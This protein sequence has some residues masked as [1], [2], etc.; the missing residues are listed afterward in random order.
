MLEYKSQLPNKVMFVAP[1][2]SHDDVTS[3]RFT[4]R[5]AKH[6]ASEIGAVIYINV[7]TTFNIKDFFIQI[8]RIRMCA[9]SNKVKLIVVHWGGYAGLVGLLGSLGYKRIITYHGPDLNWDL[10]RSIISNCAVIALSKLQSLFYT[11]TISVSPKLKSKQYNNLS[12]VAPMPVDFDHFKPDARLLQS[13][14]ASS[15]NVYFICGNDPV[16]KGLSLALRLKSVADAEKL[17]KFSI[18]DQ[19]IPYESL[20]TLL[21][22][23]DCLVF[24]SFKEGSPNIVR[25][26]LACNVPVVSVDVGDVRS[27]LHGMPNCYIVDRDPYL[28]HMSILKSING[29]SANLRDRAAQINNDHSSSIV[30]IYRKI[31]VN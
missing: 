18:F 10:S 2:K 27:V 31:M 19:L 14:Q 30:A 8:W 21:S 5:L 17:Y 9:K 12:Y 25:E 4:H 11:A 28:I 15:K 24:L 16:G 7:L 22:S 29:E 20:P 3:M 23:A 6:I 13:I 1:G 26:A